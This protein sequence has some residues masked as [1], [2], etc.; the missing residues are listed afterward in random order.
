[1]NRST[2]SLPSSVRSMGSSSA[3]I[4][5]GSLLFS[6]GVRL[7]RRLHFGSKALLISAVFAVPIVLMGVT[8]VR[9][10]QQQLAQTRAELDGVRVVQALL[11][12]IE[13]TSAQRADAMA[14]ASGRPTS[15]A[16]GAAAYQARLAALSAVLASG[17]GRFVSADARKRLPERLPALPQAGSDPIEPLEIYS[18]I[19]QDELAMLKE[20][21]AASGLAEDADPLSR[22]LL[23]ASL[24]G[25]PE[26]SDRISYL[27]ALGL[28]A[29]RS[30]QI[31]PSQQ[32]MVSD[33]LPMIEYFEADVVDQL[34]AAAALDASV[35]ARLGEQLPSAAEVRGLSRRY[36]LGAAVNGDPAR[37]EKSARRAL[38]GF[39]AARGMGLELATQML[40]ARA[41]KASTQRNLFG[42]GMIAAFVVAGYLFWSFFLV[43]K[44]GLDLVKGHLRRM[45]EGDFS[46]MPAPPWGTDEPAHVIE[47]LRKA[48]VAIAALIRS[49]H[50][51]AHELTATGGD[52]ADNASELSERTQ[53]ASENLRVQ[54]AAM[55]QVGAQVAASA[56]RAQA[57][58]AFAADNANSAVQGGQAIR[59]MRDTMQEIQRSSARIGDIVSVI[60]G[61]AFQTNLL[62]LNAAVEAARAGEAGR[63]FAVV[64]SEVR[65]LAQ[66]SAGAA[67]EISQLVKESIRKVDVGSQVAARAG[68]AVEAAVGNAGQISTFMGEIVT[69]AREQSTGVAH[70]GDAMRS[71]DE[72]SRGNLALVEQTNSTA[73]A[74]RQ[75]AEA[76]EQLVMSFSLAEGR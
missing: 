6:P 69:A 14:L 40:E 50:D 43:T 58:A 57:A 76:L 61:I 5:G 13:T 71:L 55:Q 2:T 1:M 33:R 54:A 38:D 7:F 52:I 51:A 75:H 60:D 68:D 49:V 46:H 21:R 10:S 41:A 72:E 42:A 67:K 56:E 28:Q 34:Q 73:F 70:A 15:G 19:I 64:A 59:E 74:L 18:Q 65:A 26:L 48:H 16:D 8:L 17:G 27:M 20:V 62:A 9:A 39:A 37:F 25:I 35:K 4:P 66:R 29:M 44:G 3:G 45:A 22:N 11:P 47:D 63:G 24:T 23:H 31:E 32:R 30:G 53:A 36:L 12:L